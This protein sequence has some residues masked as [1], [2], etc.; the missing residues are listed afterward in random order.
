MAG[1][2]RRDGDNGKGKDLGNVASLTIRDVVLIMAA[3]VSVVVAWG[4]YGT[5]LSLVESAQVQESLDIT[6][7]KESLTREIEELKREVESQTTKNDN[8]H[9]EMRKDQRRFDREQAR[10]KVIVD[11]AEKNQEK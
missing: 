8:E 4:V 11:R 5:R 7:I 6:E 1:K 2:T 3:V 9:K 10:R